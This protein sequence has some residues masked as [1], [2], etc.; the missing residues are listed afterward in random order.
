MHN[1]VNESLGKE[2]FNCA[3]IGEF[4]D[5]GCADEEKEG[6]NSA[7]GSG[8]DEEGKEMSPEEVE[9]LTGANGR[10]LDPQKVPMLPHVKVE[11]RHRHGYPNP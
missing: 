10:D 8:G 2:V 9:R 5:C 7:G 3:E 6:M 11:K 4:Y 1:E